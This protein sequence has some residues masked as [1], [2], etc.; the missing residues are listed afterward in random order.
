MNNI[1]L[2]VVDILFWKWINN[3]T[4]CVYVF[5]IRYENILL[6]VLYL[7]SMFL[8][9][10]EYKPLTL[11][12]MP[13]CLSYVLWIIWKLQLAI[14]KIISIKIDEHRVIRKLN[15][16]WMTCTQSSMCMKDYEYWYDS[17]YWKVQ[18]K[19]RHN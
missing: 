15:K 2:Y 13:V 17:R 18:E 8:H 4:V 19:N 7:F 12:A 14:R 1:T 9:K 11:P 16:I 10:V 6:Y 5:I 3:V